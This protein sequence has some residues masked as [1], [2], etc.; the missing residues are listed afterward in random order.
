MHLPSSLAAD[1]SLLREFV[2]WA[3]GERVANGRNL[4]ILEQRL[5]GEEE[6]TDKAE[7]ER[8]GLPDTWIHDRDGWALVIESKIESPLTKDQL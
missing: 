8:R 6:A 1:P 7:A 2:R 5:A 3:T 4:E